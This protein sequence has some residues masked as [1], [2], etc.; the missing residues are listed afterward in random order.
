MN[1][2]KEQKPKCCLCGAELEPWP[3]GYGYG[4]NPWPLSENEND[5]CCDFCDRT[6]VLP[7]RIKMARAS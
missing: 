1:E 7:A 6:K 4:N 5:R 3:G 2:Q